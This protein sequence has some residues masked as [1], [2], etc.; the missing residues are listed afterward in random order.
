MLVKRVRNAMVGLILAS[1]RAHVVSSGFDLLVEF[2]LVLVPERRVSNQ[3]DV[4]DHTCTQTH[5][6]CLSGSARGEALVA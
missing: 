2:V 5:S 1:G 3:E 6:F 4:E